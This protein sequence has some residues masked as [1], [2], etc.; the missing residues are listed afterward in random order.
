MNEPK[1][2]ISKLD[3]Q[4]HPEGGHYKEV[5]RS[6][7]TITSHALPDRF[8]GDRSCSTAI[9]YFLRRGEFSKFHRIKSD[10]IWHFY[11]G[12]PMQ[13][14]HIDTDGNIV[15]RQLGI[16]IENDTIPQ[17]LV[18]AGDWFAAQSLGD[19][20]L[21]GCTVSPGFDFTDFEMADRKKLISAFPQHQQIIEEFS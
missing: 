8:S 11:A 6:E 3:L 20:S 1:D 21:V 10:E 16:D 13:I 14:I 15:K 17:L 2:W 7:E 5:Y 19:Y 4:A 12:S 9:Y 18:C